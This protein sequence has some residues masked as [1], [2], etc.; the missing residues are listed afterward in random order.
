MWAR[1]GSTVNEYYIYMV[2]CCN[3]AELHS[4]HVVHR[5]ML[6]TRCMVLRRG[7]AWHGRRAGRCALRCGRRGVGSAGVLLGVG[8]QP[9]HRQLEHRESGGHVQRTRS[10]AV[11]RMRRATD[12]LLAAMVPEASGLGEMWGWPTSDVGESL[13]IFGRVQAQMWGRLGSTVSKSCLL[14][15]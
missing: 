1:L 14:Y 8:V 12:V 6:Q 5:C 3:E 7:V 13:C 9:E 10:N 2:T 4:T 15:L 11:A